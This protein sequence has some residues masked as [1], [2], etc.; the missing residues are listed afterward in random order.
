MLYSTEAFKAET[1]YRHARVRDSVRAGRRRRTNGAVR[2]RARRFRLPRWGLARRHPQYG[3]V[4]P[5]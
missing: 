2:L 5:E 3:R 1:E 4:A